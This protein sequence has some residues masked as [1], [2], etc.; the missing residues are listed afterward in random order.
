MMRANQLPKWAN[1]LLEWF[2]KAELVEFIQGDLIELYE[3]RSKQK[4][5]SRAKAQYILDVLSVCRPFAFKK[6]RLN[7]NN[8]AMFKNYYK[9]AIRNLMRHKMYSF[10]KI[11]GF[12]LGVA[13]CVLIALFIIDEL[14]YDNHYTDAN[15]IYRLI[16]TWKETGEEGKWPA[17]QPPLAGMVRDEIPEVEKIGRMIAYD[18]WYLAGDNLMR[19]AGKTQNVYDNGFA[20]SDQTFIEILDLTMLYGDVNNALAKPNTIIL[21]K[22]KAD[23]YFPNENPVGKTIILNDDESNPFEVTGVMENLPTTTH[24]DFEFLIT[25]TGVEFWPG[26]QTNWCCSNYDTF[27]KLKAGTSPGDI[28]PKIEAIKQNHLVAYFEERNRSDIND[29]KNYWGYELQP[30]GDIHLRSSDVDDRYVHGDIKIV[31]MFAA[32]AILILS[33]ACVNFINLSTAKSANR[34]KEVGLRKVVGS[35]K[36]N[37]IGQF[38]TESILFSFISFILGIIIARLLLPFFNQ[39]ANKSLS[40]P[41]TEWWFIPIMLV[42][43]LL[44]GFLAGLY[45]SFYLSRFIPIEVLKGKLSLGSKSSSLQGAMVVFQFAASAILI[46]GAVVVNKQMNY[47]LNSNLGFDKEQLILIRGTNTLDEKLVPFKNELRALPEVKSVTTSR[48]FPV[49]GTG[50]DQNGFW[51]EGRENMDAPVGAQAWRVDTEYIDALGIELIQGRNFTKN[52]ASD[53]GSIIVNETMAKELG[54]AEPL[55]KRI[56]N[57][58]YPRTIIGVIKDFHFESLRGEINPLCLIYDTRTDITAVKVGTDNMLETTEAITAIWDRV[59]PNQPI[60]YDFLDETFAAMYDNVKRTGQIFASFSILAVIIA[61]LG[62]FALSAFMV[63]QRR[64]EISIRKVLGAPFMSL[65]SVLTSN[66]MKLVFIALIVALPTGWYLMN[67]WLANYTYKTSLTLDIFILSG[68]LIVMIAF[69]TLSYEVVRAVR[70]NPA[71]TLHAE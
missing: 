42:S 38:L 54:L 32:I 60:R 5:Q 14:Q 36:S 62:L 47:I 37:L 46:I 52:M 65:F 6:T 20:Y 61:C 63:E 70:V 23:K 28:M 2:C 58:E 50:R 21:S 43:V 35:Q 40:F 59:V 4:G 33:L 19:E 1:K 71:D 7:S 41:L 24:F 34:A 49:S 9:V 48:Y 45:P 53:S 17:Q 67:S 8:Y 51:N 69:I 27:V 10:V 44:I 29:F 56:N 55:G 68:L 25:L 66:F 64:K 3:L 11:G 22:R 30:I 18:G 13:A 16:N 57:F 15:R 39:V 26:E 12:S 31:W